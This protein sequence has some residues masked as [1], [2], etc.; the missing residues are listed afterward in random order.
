MPPIPANT[1]SA[2]R[3][4]CR[5]SPM[6]NSRRA[7][8]PTTKKNSVIRPLFSHPRRS[9]LIEWSPS[10]TTRSV[11]QTLRY[12]DASML[13]QSSAAIVASSSTPALPVSVRRNSRSGVSRL[14]AQAVLPDSGPVLFVSAIALAVCQLRGSRLERVHLVLAGLDAAP[15]RLRDLVPGAGQVT[16][17]LREHQP[18]LV[19][20]L[21]QRRHLGVQLPQL[22]DARA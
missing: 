14:R 17:R 10:R 13:I 7:S 20:E 6:S 11:S 3:R 15:L 1:G 2:T 18:G 8:R 9:R 16:D 5:S 4:R 21:G 12:D 22:V 19:R